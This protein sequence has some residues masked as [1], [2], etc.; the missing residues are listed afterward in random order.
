MNAN[1]SRPQGDAGRIVPRR[2]KGRFVRRLA[3]AL[4]VAA[5]LTVA[6]A[7][8]QAGL[9]LSSSSGWVEF[10]ERSVNEVPST[11]ATFN[12]RTV[13]GA[14]FNEMLGPGKGYNLVVDSANGPTQVVSGSISP[15]SL[16]ATAIPNTIGDGG[17]GSG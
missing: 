5:P 17:F 8:A 15:S 11:S 6:P 3:M 13:N 12:T 4:M 2:P 14:T 16:V 10:P 9:V 7:A 1:R